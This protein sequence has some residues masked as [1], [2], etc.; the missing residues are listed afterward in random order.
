MSE[1]TENAAIDTRIRS[2]CDIAAG[3]APSDP[4]ALGKSITGAKKD[5]NAR[6]NGPQWYRMV[7]R[8]SGWQ[9][10]SSEQ[11][12]NGN[13][14]A[15]DRRATVYGDVFP[16]EIVVSHDRGKPVDAAWLICTPDEQGKVMTPCGIR[17]RRDGQLVFELPDASKIVLSDPRQ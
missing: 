2:A 12:P 4:D 1:T 16:G 3:R 7:Y 6:G 8:E 17:K 9:Y 10:V 13:Y 14:L 15:S 5:L 11:L